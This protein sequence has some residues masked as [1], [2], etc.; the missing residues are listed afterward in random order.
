V[1]MH[2]EKKGKVQTQAERAKRS[3]ESQGTRSWSAGEVPVL[4]K[5]WGLELKWGRARP[6][7]LGRRTSSNPPVHWFVGFGFQAV[8]MDI[9]SHHAAAAVFHPRSIITPVRKM[10]ISPQRCH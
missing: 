10:V 6:G 5:A 1:Q 9:I 7:C 8:C 3:L 4:G 2:K